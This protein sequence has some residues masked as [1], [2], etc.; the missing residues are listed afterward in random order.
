MLQKRK[1]RRQTVKGK[2]SAEIKSPDHLIFHVL[3]TKLNAPG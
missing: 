1:E 3:G 2:K